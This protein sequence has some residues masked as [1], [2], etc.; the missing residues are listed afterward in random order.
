MESLNT[1]FRT[2]CHHLDGW[3]E[4]DLFLTDC[5]P[6]AFETI[7]PQIKLIWKK[8]CQP[9]LRSLGLVYDSLHHTLYL[10]T[11]RCI[12]GQKLC[13]CVASTLISKLNSLQFTCKTP[14]GRDPGYSCPLNFFGWNSD[15]RWPRCRY[16]FGESYVSDTG[17]IGYQHI[18]DWTGFNAMLDMGNLL[19]DFGYTNNYDNLMTRVKIL[20]GDKRLK[21]PATIFLLLVDES[22]TFQMPEPVVNERSRFNP[23]YF[24]FEDM[25]EASDSSKLLRNI[26][27]VGHC[28]FGELTSCFLDVYRYYRESDSIALLRRVDCLQCMRAPDGMNTVEVIDLHISDIM[29]P[30]HREQLQSGSDEASIPFHLDGRDLIRYSNCGIKAAARTRLQSYD[31]LMTHIVNDRRLAHELSV[32]N[33]ED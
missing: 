26:E 22:P 7:S 9:R 1:R 29:R 13:C 32:S 14:S 23:E 10:S 30:E 27:H 16:K 3:V 11:I 24:R 8:E 31:R 5:P 4:R 6:D 12:V 21:E 19:F 17:M 28:W 2:L 18:V 33:L 15:P 25:L 20:I